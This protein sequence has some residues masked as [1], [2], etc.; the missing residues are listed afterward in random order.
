MSECI[1]CW[2]PVCVPVRFLLEEREL[3]CMK[4]IS[5]C[6]YC[7][8]H[9]YRQDIPL[10]HRPSKMKC[11]YQCCDIKDEVEIGMDIKWDEMDTSEKECPVCKKKGVHKEIADH[12][13]E[14]C[15]KYCTDCSMWVLQPHHCLV[16][17]YY[18]CKK[19]IML[20]EDLLQTETLL[21]E[22]VTRRIMSDSPQWKI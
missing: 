2:E 5:M 1:I 4:N 18:D 15:M 3:E 14:E 13:M 22:Q 9:Y 12:L 19:R 16:Q 7:A 17:Q 8:I 10:H 6:L 21:M 11:L 20:L